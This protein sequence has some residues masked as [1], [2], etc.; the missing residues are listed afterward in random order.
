MKEAEHERG[1]EAA[2]AE[3]ATGQ[4]HRHGKHCLKAAADRP[5][6][7]KNNKQK[8]TNHKV[9]HVAAPDRA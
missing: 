6:N 2:H 7:Y 5:S 1:E 4:D 3:G 8:K 9:L